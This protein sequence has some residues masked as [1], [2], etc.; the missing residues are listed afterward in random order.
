MSMN[1]GLSEEQREGVVAILNT[2]LSDEY[3]LYTKT[4]NYHWNVVGPQFHDLHKFF[5]AQYNALNE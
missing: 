2:L 1:I 5:E 3:L 4:R